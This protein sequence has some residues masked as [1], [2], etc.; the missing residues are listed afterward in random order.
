MTRA[1]VAA[2]LDGIPNLYN[3]GFIVIKPT[4][5]S[6][7][8]YQLI[9]AMTSNSATTDDQMALN[10]AIQILTKQGLEASILNRHQ[11]VSGLDYFEKS[12]RWFAVKDAK[13]CDHEEQN[14]C[15]VAVHNNWIVSKAAKVY[16][17]REHMLWMYDGNDQ[18]YT[19]NTRFY[20]TYTNQKPSSVCD[21][22]A[23]T[24]SEISALKT[25]LTIGYLLNRTTILPRFHCESKADDCPLNFFLQMKNF[26]SYFAN[27]YRENS[28]LYHPKVPLNVKYGL[29]KL[30]LVTGRTIHSNTA[31]ARRNTQFLLLI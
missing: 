28:F 6:K 8:L 4:K 20:L 3:A 23:V 16:R 10:S 13:K 31:S 9:K 12:R 1:D 21:Q 7:Q 22:S 24:K 29:S 19:S 5:F 2:L 14:K 15:A 25:A 11:F 17:F 30:Q 18:Y 27:N 26:D